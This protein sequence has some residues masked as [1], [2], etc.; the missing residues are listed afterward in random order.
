[1]NL[2]GIDAWRL[3]TTN[4][5]RP[6]AMCLERRT[7]GIREYQVW[8]KVVLGGMQTVPCKFRNTGALPVC[9]MACPRWPLPLY[10]FGTSC[11]VPSG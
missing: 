1:M 4:C 6:M 5:M 3:W 8:E 10:G 2:H 7:V 9:R 11:C